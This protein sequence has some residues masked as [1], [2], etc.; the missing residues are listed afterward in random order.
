[1]IWGMSIVATTG[2]TSI[3]SRSRCPRKTCRSRSPSQCGMDISCADV[4][5]FAAPSAAARS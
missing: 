1:M 4:T 5:P 3:G 2:S